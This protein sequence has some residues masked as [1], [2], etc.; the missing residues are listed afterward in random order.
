MIILLNNFISYHVQK[1][2][3]ASKID[4][5]KAILFS[6]PQF[7]Q[8][9]Q[10]KRKFLQFQM[11][12]VQLIFQIWSFIFL[13]LTF[14]IVEKDSAIKKRSRGYSFGDQKEDDQKR[15]PPKKIQL[16]CFLC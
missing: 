14:F 1:I 12:K 3:Q 5:D 2:S 4:R 13:K 6:K 9:F 10:K 11:A 8:N 16:I 15:V 7:F